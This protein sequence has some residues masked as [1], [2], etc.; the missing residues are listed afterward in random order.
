MRMMGVDSV[1]YHEATVLD[2]GDDHPGLALDYYASRG[3]TPLRWGGR[4]AVRLGLVGPVSKPA[5][6]A[7]FGP[8]GAI[9]PVLGRRLTATKRPGLELVVAA[10]KSVAEL[11]V[12]GRAEDMHRILDVE[13]AAT[14]EYL[15]QV[16]LVAGGRRGRAATMTGTSGM[17]YATTR[18]ATTRA[19]DPGPHDHVLIVNAVEMLDAKGGW[20]APNTALW[21][22]ELHAATVV[23]RLHAAWEATQL[24]YAIRPDA[25]R[26]G[27]LG[28]WAIDGIPQAVLDLHSKR[29]AE[30][31]ELIGIDASPRARAIAAR[32]TREYKRHTPVTELLPL[33]QRELTDA[34]FAPLELARAIDNRAVDRPPLSPSLTVAEQQR[35]VNEVLSMD[36]PLAERKVFTRREIITVIGPHLYGRHPSELNRTLKAVLAHPELVPLLP[37]KAG[38]LPGYTLAS[39]LA[40]EHAIA[41]TLTRAMDRRAGDRVDPPTIHAA[42]AATEAGLGHPLTGGQRAVV[43]M[44][45]ESDARAALIVGV[46]GSGK[47]TALTAIGASY[48]SAG[49]RVV[50]TATAG[51]AARSLEQAAGIESSTLASLRWRI[52]HQQLTL[53]PRT[54]VILDEAGMTDDPDLLA[55]VTHADIA[56]AKVVLVGDDR[57]LSPVGPGGALGALIDRWHPQVHYLTDNVRQHTPGEAAALHQL[58]DGS[59]DHALSWMADHD[60]IVTAPDRRELLDTITGHWNTDRG[61]GRD[62]ILLAWRRDNVAALN[63]HARRAVDHTG[64]LTGPTLYVDEQTGY[65]AGD[66]ILALAPSD[67]RR[68]LTSQRSTVIRVDPDARALTVLPDGGRDLVRLSGDELGPDCLAHGYATTVHRAQGLTVDTAHVLEDG[69]GR[70][71]AYVKT[72]R[73]RAT[74]HLYVHA[75]SLDQARED[76]TAS[77]TSE[78]RKTWAID[79]HTPGP[80]PDTTRSELAPV[81]DAMRRLQLEAETQAVRS[82]MPPGLAPDLHRARS[83]VARLETVLDDLHHGRGPAATPAV[84]AQARRLDHHQG[85]AR[86]LQRSL[87]HGYLGWRDHRRTNNQLAHAH[88]AVA[89]GVT[90]LELLVGPIAAD[91]TNRLGKATDRLADLERRHDL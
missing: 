27:R 3:E 83:D 41:D 68:L 14:L 75:D 21:R 52:E 64:G 53:D 40:T 8:G 84:V 25:G 35:L 12:I 38:L 46:A 33:W 86:Q 79:T 5:Y 91:L 78:H 31:D 72:S 45:C 65:Q 22:D 81:I 82:L 60:R 77:W 74:T 73:A 19:G 44:V 55:L 63:H 17:V 87:D 26:S 9:D 57:Q 37:S 51:Q 36:G 48:T 23:G 11:G 30:I 32:A 10:H 70:E 49:Y 88:D 62:T 58:R 90:E 1:A 6:E 67:D 18:H 47:T 43:E 15:E 2:R 56:G 69:G 39:V 85:T 7:M 13:T 66:R 29:S 89:D 16:T 76:L 42:V 80:A 20:K 59:I 4:G 34:G 24:G 28:H 61:A 71:L 50:G 54:V